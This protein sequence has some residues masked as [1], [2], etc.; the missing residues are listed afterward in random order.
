[1]RA[2]GALRTVSFTLLAAAFESSFATPVRA[3][4]TTTTVVSGR[5]LSSEA[6][7]L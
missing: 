6:V 7:L 5:S 1:V 4:S 2:S 3:G